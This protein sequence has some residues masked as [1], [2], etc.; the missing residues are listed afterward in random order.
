MKDI[1]QLV[2]RD[3]I[4]AYCMSL[5]RTAEFRD[6][7]AQP[8]G[9]V[10][11]WIDRFAEYP[12]FFHT[13]SDPRVEKAHFSPR[14]NGIGHRTY[15][16]AA[17]NDLF[18]M[19]EIA[20]ACMLVYD[21]TM[22]WES[23]A[24]KMADNE[25]LASLESETLAYFALPGLREKG[26]PEE[27]WADRFLDGPSDVAV[28]SAHRSFMLMERYRAR[29]RPDDALERRI[30]AYREENEAWALIWRKRYGEV[31]ATM[32]AFRR[33]SM[34]S[35]ASALAWLLEALEGFKAGADGRA[36]YPWPDE[37]R[38]FAEVY[39]RTRDASQVA[40]TPRPTLNA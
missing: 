27:I 9:Y 30:A 31:E 24:S 12:R 22:T 16:N 36:E 32:S 15:D 25:M 34:D 18:Y 20:H 33:R 35:R 38:A 3:E 7:H 19:H 1:I 40:A 17:I 2:E 14:W 29:L 23:W 6:S 21:E 11:R 5:W 37:A 39:W 10:R 13:L 8:D 28:R 26:F 4:H